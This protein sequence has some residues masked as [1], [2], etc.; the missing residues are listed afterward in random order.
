MD[1]RKIEKAVQSHLE[2]LQERMPPISTIPQMPTMLRDYA[3][4][5][6]KTASEATAK[7]LKSAN[8][9]SL[10]RAHR[11]PDEP[12][13]IEQHLAALHA[14]NGRA[15]RASW[16]LCQHA[17]EAPHIRMD[18]VNE[19]LTFSIENIQ[20]AIHVTK[21]VHRHFRDLGNTLSDEPC[22][23]RAVESKTDDINN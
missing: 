17:F 18:S 14:A 19:S 9:P 12:L 11:S 3:K 20:E 10:S 22:F 6:N 21:N 2:K 5:L 8:I 15:Q 4:L 1:S 7:A 23:Y 16:N 13:K